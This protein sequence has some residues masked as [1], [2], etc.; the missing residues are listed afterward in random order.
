MPLAG[1]GTGL[2]QNLT[3]PAIRTHLKVPE[4]RLMQVEKYSMGMVQSGARQKTH[5]VEFHAKYIKTVK[6]RIMMQ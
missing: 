3:F 4:M 5:H 1:L 6:V 2:K